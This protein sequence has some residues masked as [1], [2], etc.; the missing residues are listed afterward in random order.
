MIKLWEC[1]VVGAST[2]EDGEPFNRYIFGQHLGQSMSRLQYL[3]RG[4]I[5]GVEKKEHD[6][7]QIIMKLRKIGDCSASPTQ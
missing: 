5:L 3:R 4:S 7:Y 1:S 2:V 6:N